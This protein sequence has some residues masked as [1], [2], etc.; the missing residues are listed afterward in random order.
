MT[1]YGR[2]PWIDRFPKSRIPSYPRFRGP[3]DV[4][5]AIV[6]GG[7]TG[8]ATA[9]A[10]AAAGVN[11]ALLEA[12]RIGHGSSGR[13]AGWIADDPG[14]PFFDLE[15]ALGGRAAR[16]AWTAWRRAALDFTALIRRLGI[17]CDLEPRPTV[18]L[19]LSAEQIARVRR[20]QKVRRGAGLDAP[21]VNARVLGADVGI[22]GAGGIR[23][24][25]S[26]TLDPY[27]ATLG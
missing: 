18:T 16:R 5:V 27:C 26:A 23:T 24:K 25:D 6:G 4:D 21:F 19:A 2:S 8:C 7:L 22:V 10:F 11:V 1:K 14:I 20:E 9:Y 15:R 3:L 13:A 12:D 17:K